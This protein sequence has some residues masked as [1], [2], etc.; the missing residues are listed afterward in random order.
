VSRLY[1]RRAILSAL[2]RAGFSVVGQRGSHVKLRGRRGGRDR[3]VI[4]KHPAREVPAGTFAAI[5]RQAGLSREEFE[6]FL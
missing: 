1:P 4:V 2:Q 5:L 6:G 3:T